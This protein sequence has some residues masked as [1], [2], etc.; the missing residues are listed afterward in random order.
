MPQPS[1]L[2]RG[3]G[4]AGWGASCRGEGGAGGQE[5]PRI[6]GCLSVFTLRRLGSDWGSDASRVT[7]PA[8][9]ESGRLRVSSLRGLRGG[10]GVLAAHGPGAGPRAERVS[11]RPPSPRALRASHSHFLIS[12]AGFLCREILF[13]L[14]GPAPVAPLLRSGPSRSPALRVLRG[15]ARASSRLPPRGPPSPHPSSYG[16]GGTR[17]LGNVPPP[18]PMSYHDEGPRRA[19]V[20]VAGGPLGRPRAEPRWGDRKKGPYLCLTGCS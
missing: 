14:Q 17:S 11:K 6:W 7:L 12:S 16:E 13:S 5:P 8:A 15:Q 3:P 19:A 10:S 20:L 2:A 1:G 9:A 4:P 18:P